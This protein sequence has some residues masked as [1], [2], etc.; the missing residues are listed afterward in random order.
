MIDRRGVDR[1]EDP[2]MSGAQRRRGVSVAALLLW[3]T[4]TFP[5]SLTRTFRA[6]DAARRYGV[7]GVMDRHTT[8]RP[9]PPP[10]KEHRAQ[11]GQ[12]TEKRGIMS[13][14]LLVNNR[15]TGPV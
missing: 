12:I 3:H 13:K 7:E 6:L 9:Q 10:G 1:I 15:L 4:D 5:S 11:I 14:Q 8:S 2:S